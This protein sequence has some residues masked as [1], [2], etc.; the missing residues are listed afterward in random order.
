[1]SLPAEVIESPT[2]QVT[3]E[4]FS[5]IPDRTSESRIVPQHD[6]KPC[7]CGGASAKANG[8]GSAQA[9]GN[10]SAT[11]MYSYV[12]AVGHIG[13]RFPSIGLEK[14]FAQATG[15]DQSAGMT[16]HQ[17]FHSLLSQRK[18]RYLTR[19]VCWT[20]SIEGLETYLL[21]PRDPGDYELLLE[22]LRREPSP[23]DVDVV[24]GVRG[25]IAA[26]EMCNGLMLPIVAF[27]QIYSF[28]RDALI[29]TIPR[30]D[31]VT[32]KDFSATAHELFERIMLLADN[33]GATDENRALNY[34]AVRYPAIYAMAAE[35]HGKNASLTGVEVQPS[36]FNNTRS[37]MDTI[38]SVT[39]RNTDVTEK[40]FVRVDV[41]EE[42]P[43]LVTK[44][45]PYLNR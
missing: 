2:G 16:D 6:G 26:P 21:Q 14:E 23:L 34:L 3:R 5:P 40:F 33:A 13:V 39:N 41:T 25:P 29:K 31:K 19:Q 20:L 30:P 43:F 44:L 36:T 17:A 15:R 10:G 22:A 18:N 24:I 1:M 42:F 9:N 7:G 38:F 35:A 37:I 28:D 32:E 4:S 8:N 27:D 11:T 12:Y 45:S